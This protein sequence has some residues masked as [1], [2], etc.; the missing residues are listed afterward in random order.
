MGWSHRTLTSLFTC[1][2]LSAFMDQRSLHCSPRFLLHLVSVASGNS[3]Q[4]II[5]PSVTYCFSPQLLS[6]YPLHPRQYLLDPLRWFMP[7][8]SV[9]SAPVNRAHLPSC[10]QLA[11]SATTPGPCTSSAS[12]LRPG[13]VRQS[14]A[15]FSSFT[16]ILFPKLY[17]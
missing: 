16:R 15:M 5:L 12:T 11:S 8:S 6:P 14:N 3:N 10:L 9:F 1:A 17:H 2:E 4:G 7:V 13:T